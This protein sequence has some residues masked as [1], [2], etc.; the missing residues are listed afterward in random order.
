VTGGLI[1]RNKSRTRRELAEA[2]SHL[3]LER[4]YASTTVQDIV[5][6]VDIS[7]RTFFRYF[8]SKEDV[9][10]AIAS[11]SMDDCLDH[12]AEHHPDEPLG[13]VLRSL[14]AA[15]LSRVDEDPAASRAFQFMLRDTPAL[16]GRWLE[17]Q[18]RSSDRLGEAL[19]PWFP[20]GSHPIAPTLTAAAALLAVDEVM[21]YW[22]SGATDAPLLSL[23][24]DALG[25][26]RNPLAAGAAVGG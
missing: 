15:S 25:L 22:A 16:R 14:M 1:E 19:R 18:R 13:E 7:P 6:A 10:T 17:E 8:P 9:I 4:G 20:P 23:L 11:L 26:L 21:A 5:D 12:L 3:F 24:D 2:A